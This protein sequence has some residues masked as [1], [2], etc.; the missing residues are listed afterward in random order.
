MNAERSEAVVSAQARSCNIDS[1]DEGAREIAS[2]VQQGHP[3]W[4]VL[5]GSY[6]GQF[7]AFPLFETSALRWIETESPGQLT[8]RM[9][10]I[11]EAFAWSTAS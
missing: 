2:R 9:R 1:E 3:G 11:E 6:S 7:V 5:F 4:L 10:E 8:R